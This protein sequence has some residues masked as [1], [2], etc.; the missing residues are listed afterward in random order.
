MGRRLGHLLSGEGRPEGVNRPGCHSPELGILETRGPRLQETKAEGLAS[1]QCALEKGL[2]AQRPSSSPRTCVLPTLA[3]CVPNQ[4]LPTA[5]PFGAIRCFWPRPHA[6]SRVQAWRESRQWKG[7]EQAFPKG[8][9]KPT[10]VSP[11]VSLWCNYHCTLGKCSGD[12]SPASRA[13]PTA[14]GLL[15]PVSFLVPTRAR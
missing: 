5:A 14:L 11:P 4:P 13:P 10:P 9:C 15:W 1:G 8:L 7:A 6:P 12:N 2:K 3:D